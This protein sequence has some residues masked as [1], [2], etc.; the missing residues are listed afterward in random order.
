MKIQVQKCRFTGK[1]FEDKKEFTKHL[2][3]LRKDMKAA[4][5]DKRLKE[6]FNDWIIA[7]KEKIT[8]VDMIAPWIL[9]NQQKL[10]R[11]CNIM[12]HFSFGAKFYQGD[13]FTKIEIE[14]YYNPN[15][16]NTHSCPKNGILNWWCKDV[17]DNGNKLPRG[18][19]GYNGNIRSTLKRIKKHDNSYPSD[20]LFKFIGLH[21]GSG[22]GGND[23]TRYGISI[24]LA[25]WSGLAEAKSFEI[26]KGK[27]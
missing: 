9:E 21:P 26:L 15:L 25:D 24:Y 4:R 23:N 19:P 18:Y 10:M 6:E 7:E 5:E 2:R 11:A 27:K 8:D 17:D 1:L 14:T 22:G 20:S 3:T 12:H 16:S 13:E